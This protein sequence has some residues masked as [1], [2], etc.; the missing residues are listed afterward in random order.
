MGLLVKLLEVIRRLPLQDSQINQL[1]VRD[2]VARL[3]KSRNTRVSRAAAALVQDW[4]VRKGRSMW[5]SGVLL[6]KGRA[7]RTARQGQPAAAVAPLPHL[8]PRLVQGPGAGVAG[9]HPRGTM[10]LGPG[11]KASR[12]APASAAASSGRGR[13]SAAGAP[14]SVLGLAQ[15]RPVALTRE[16]RRRLARD[17]IAQEARARL[18]GMGALAGTTLWSGGPPALAVTV[19]IRAGEQSAEAAVLESSI[20]L[21]PEPPADTGPVPREPEPIGLFSAPARSQPAPRVPWAPTDPME[22]AEQAQFLRQKGV[23]L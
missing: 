3:A 23:R 21:G 10:L 18:S 13:G 9:P 19:E 1:G 7:S 4:E 16:D 6:S 15:P 17:A 8:A 12:A 22:R 2:S 20:L 11:P 5:S 14:L